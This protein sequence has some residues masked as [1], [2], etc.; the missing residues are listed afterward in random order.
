MRW[1]ILIPA[2]A[3]LGPTTPPVDTTSDVPRALAAA[4]DDERKSEA[5]YRAVLQQFGDARPFA[6]VVHAESCHAG[7]L[8]PLFESRGLEVP[9]NP[10]DGAEISVPDSLTRA[11]EQAVELE[12][13]NVA[14][15][16]GLLAGIEDPEVAR[17]FERLRRASLEHH[18]PAFERCAEGR[19]MRGSG[20]GG[21][22]GCCGGCARA[23]R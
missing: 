3:L 6:H 1:M 12:R 9:V 10:W 14:M 15:Y 22:G 23:R 20:V 8:L 2:L 11:C 13:L 19:P 18:L 16:D 21:G 7:Q 5:T 17:V 4:L